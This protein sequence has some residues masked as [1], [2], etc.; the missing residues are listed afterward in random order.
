M[1]QNFDDSEHMAVSPGHRPWRRPNRRKLA[2]VGGEV[3][4]PHAL[5]KNV[6]ADA[7]AA[8]TDA[9]ASYG[10]TDDPYP[11][12]DD[13]GFDVD[14]RIAQDNRAYVTLACA[15]MLLLGVVLVGAAYV[16]S[17]RRVITIEPMPIRQSMNW[18]GTS[19]YQTSQRTP[20]CV[21]H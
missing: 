13:A 10:V 9:W 6:Q 1:A 15:T 8:K 5:A 12:K 2:P 20:Y 19:C 21:T 3:Q 17:L 18:S 7:A 11:W 16:H 4:V 14:A